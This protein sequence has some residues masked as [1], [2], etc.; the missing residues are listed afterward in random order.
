MK[1]LA[2]TVMSLC[3]AAAAGGAATA[4]TCLE[5]KIARAGSQPSSQGPADYFTGSVRVDSLFP[6]N[7]TERS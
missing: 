4:Q 5:L 1:A 7:E 2:A 6:A 3:V